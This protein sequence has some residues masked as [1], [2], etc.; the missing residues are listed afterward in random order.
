MEIRFLG[1]EILKKMKDITTAYPD[2]KF[3]TYGSL[4]DIDYLKKSLE[5]GAISYTLRPV[6]PSELNKCLDAY[7]SYE[8]ARENLKKEEHMLDMEYLQNFKLFEDKFLSVLI[9][10]TV[11]D[12]EEI[13]NS[14]K[15]FNINLQPPYTVAIFRIDS[16]R[17]CIINK[18]QKEKHLISFRLLKII[19]NSLP[20]CKA[21]INLFNEVVVI[22]GGELKLKSLVDDMTSIKLSI[23]EQTDI[24][25]SCGI[26][27]SYT[28]PNKIHI[29]FTEANSALRYRCIVGYNSVIS[30]DFVE[31]E[32]TFA[33]S[34]PYERENLLVHT[35]VIGE[36]DY[37]L[38]LLDDIFKEIN[39]YKSKFEHILSQIIMSILISINRTAFEQGLSIE[40]VSKFFDTSKVL[41]L[42]NVDEA[43][44]FL[45]TNLKTFC[46]YMVD[47]R[48]V[49]EEQIYEKAMAYIKEN[50]FKALSYKA[51]AEQF[52]CNV[53]YFRKIFDTKNDLPLEEYVTRLRIDKAKELILETNLTDDLIALKI[54]YTDV[55]T[56]RQTFKRVEGILAGDFRY[57]HKD[58]K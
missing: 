52:N 18:S 54:G 20:N 1:L 36:Y 28:E 27:R 43:Y 29:S 39:L 11:F 56:F 21:F 32:N 25:V 35:A 16:F 45:K 8:K 10:E 15:Y 49:K 7:L 30:I 53:A 3:I 37:C 9:N 57:I 14:F 6:K 23:K 46:D 50:Y 2:I 34:Y 12:D 19:K 41:K 38:K 22:L 48:K 47:F 40:P 17:K 24:L 4:N 51:L 5:F 13:E 31:P 55:N 44:L 42:K 26:G 58:K 33:S